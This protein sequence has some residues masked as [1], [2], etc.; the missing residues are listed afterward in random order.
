M[1]RFIVEKKEHKLHEIVKR[2]VFTTW[3]KYD[4]FG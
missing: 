1:T 4:K 3:R 2:R